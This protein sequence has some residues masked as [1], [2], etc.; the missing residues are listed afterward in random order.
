MTKVLTFGA[1]DILHPGHLYYLEQAKKH[2]DFLVVV[3][4]RDA[5][6]RKIKGRYPTM[7]ENDRL[8][9]VSALK[10][11][12]K[13]ML[14]NKTYDYKIIAQIK[15]DVVCLGYDQGISDQELDKWLQDA[16]IKAKIIRIKSLQSK[17][18]KSSKFKK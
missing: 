4:A 7:D 11:V 8:K 10:I 13:A 5:T 1:F 18:Y 15:P 6:V 12:D 14:G 17:K 3:I 9:I 2:G 16:N